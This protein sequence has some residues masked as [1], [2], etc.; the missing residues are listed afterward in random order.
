[1]FCFFLALLLLC[2]ATPFVYALNEPYPKSEVQALGIYEPYKKP[3]RFESVPPVF[4]KPDTPWPVDHWGASRGFKATWDDPGSSENEHGFKDDGPRS[5]WKAKEYPFEEIDLEAF[6][7]QAFNHYTPYAVGTLP[8]AVKWQKMTLKTGVYQFKLGQ[9]NDGSQKVNLKDLSPSPFLKGTR[10]SQEQL[11]ERKQASR[12]K[13]VFI[14]TQGGKVMA[15]LPIM[16]R[17]TPPEDISKVVAVLRHE[18]ARH[19]QWGKL[20]WVETMKARI[21]ESEGRPVMRFHLEEATGQVTISVC[22]KHQCYSSFVPS[23]D[24]WPYVPAKRVSPYQ[25]L[26]PQSP[27][28]TAP[29]RWDVPAHFERARPLQ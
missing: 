3:E 23:L 22:Q 29:L 27:Q 28:A 14:V 20:G 2:F 26:T 17:S 7:D 10:P 16:A 13:D 15:V 8:Y 4:A 18:N 12:S 5:F 1:M 25:G 21:D 9:W 19:P 6:A 24:V 11:E